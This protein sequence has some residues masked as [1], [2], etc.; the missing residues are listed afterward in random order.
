[1]SLEKLQLLQNTKKH[2]ENQRDKV[3][4]EACFS[5]SVFPFGCKKNYYKGSLYYLKSFLLLYHDPQ[6]KSFY[7]LLILQIA[8]LEERPGGVAKELV[9][10]ESKIYEWQVKILNV[11][12]QI[13]E[14]EETQL[15]ALMGAMNNQIEGKHDLTKTEIRVI[16][17]SFCLNYVT[18]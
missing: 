17:G 8:S 13:L 4:Q 2:Y 5:V 16:V 10:L 9:K 1:M 15:K 11:Q 12:L 6:I 18:P 14:Q 3:K 7:M